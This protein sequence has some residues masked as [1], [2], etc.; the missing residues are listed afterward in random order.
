[1]QLVCKISLLSLISCLA[2]AFQQA[3]VCCLFKM[4]SKD[5][6]KVGLIS[7]GYLGKGL[8]LDLRKELSICMY[9]KLYCQF[10][11]HPF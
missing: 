5:M 7:Y 6:L 8:G 3:S 11:P 4:K 10:I 2:T 9:L 1:M